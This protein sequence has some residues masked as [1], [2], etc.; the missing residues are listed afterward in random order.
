MYTS[1]YPGMG[2][3]PP[4]VDLALFSSPRQITIIDRPVWRVKV[5]IGKGMLHLFVCL[6]VCTLTVLILVW[7]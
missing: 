7:C 3:Y 4:R 6:T 1:T 5:L 2:P